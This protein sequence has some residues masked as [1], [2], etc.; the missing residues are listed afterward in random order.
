VKKAPTLTI[1]ATLVLS[2]LM[3]VTLCQHQTNAQTITNIEN[4]TDGHSQSS[5]CI[6]GVC[7]NSICTNDSCETSIICVNGK[8]ERLSSSIMNQFP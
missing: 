8:C 3:V 5:I 7:T 6:N 2:I 4:Q 1:F